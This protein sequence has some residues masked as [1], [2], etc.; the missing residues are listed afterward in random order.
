MK[1]ILAALLMGLPFGAFADALYSSNA[2][3]NSSNY[4]VAASSLASYS[5]QTLTF[6]LSDREVLS[7]QSDGTT[8]WH[9][10]VIESDA[11]FKA[12]MIEVSKFLT[13]GCV[14]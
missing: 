2:T 10:H 1:T 9:G 12:A 7:I 4:I 11:E 13:K 14:K 3:Q 5:P 6:S 8:T